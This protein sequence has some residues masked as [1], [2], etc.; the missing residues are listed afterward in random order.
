MSEFLALALSLPT[1]IFTVLLGFFLLY[2]LLSVL[3]A[4]QIDWLDSVI[5]FDSD[6]TILAGVPIALVAGVSTLFAWLISFAGTKFLPGSPLVKVGVGM[7]ATILGVL[8]GSRVLRPL[9]P[10]FTVPDGPHR[11]A[12]VGK[13]CTIR[14]LRV[15]DGSGT[16]EIGDI[17]AEVRCFRENDLTLGS[18]AIIYDYDE[19]SGTFHVG[20]IDP[21][22]AS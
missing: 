21:T 9:R 3:G 14:S 18:K 20:P 17:V 6:D 16:A 10:I 11:K 22:I 8:I 15:T 5:D 2:A 1:V 12:I 4:L 13:I 7:G 19:E